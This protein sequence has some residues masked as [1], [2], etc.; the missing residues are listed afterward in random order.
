[1]PDTP[2]R[3]ELALALSL[4]VILLLSVAGHVWGATG[5]V[6]Y[7]DPAYSLWDHNRYIAMAQAPFEGEL[8]LQ[9]PFCWRIL[10]PLIVHL[11]PVNYKLGF[12]AVSFLGLLATCLFLYVYQRRLG[13]GQMASLVGM[14]L[15]V[16]LWPAVRYD[17]YDPYLVDPLAMAFVAGAFYLLIT[18]R[19]KVLALWLAL[20]VANKEVVLFV[21]PA[22]FC[23]QIKQG[24]HREPMALVWRTLKISAPALIVWGT[25]RLLIQPYNRYDYLEQML[26]VIRGRYLAQGLRGLAREIYAYS[27][28][29]WGVLFALLVLR[30]RDKLHY[31]LADWPSLVYLLVVFS[32]MIFANNTHRLLIYGFPVIIPLG[33]RTLEHITQ[34]VGRSIFV[35]AAP[36]IA[37]QMLFSFGVESGLPST[38]I[39]TIL[40]LLGWLGVEIWFWKVPHKPPLID[41]L[42]DISLTTHKGLLENTLPHREFLRCIGS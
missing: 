12:F 4:A 16:Y 2:T 29:T 13:I 21:L 7:P 32:Q 19:D 5:F 39:V 31:L 17:L 3:H 14:I 15:F 33:V 37:L 40:S 22:W 23:L 27:F 28:G 6:P 1:M 25:L 8:A 41:L 36:P 18:G 26:I 10:T 20:G 38:K 30:P 42:R 34:R 9:A 11:L 35:I 24:A